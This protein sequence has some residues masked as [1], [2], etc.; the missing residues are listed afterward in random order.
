MFSLSLLGK[1]AIVGS[2][3]MMGMSIIL[4]CDGES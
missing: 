1:S 3:P 4:C 2:R